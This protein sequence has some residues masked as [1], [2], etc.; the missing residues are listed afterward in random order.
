GVRYSHIID[1]ET[2]RPI[3]HRTASVTVLAESAMMAD[4]WATAFLALGREQGME[5]AEKYE[6]A[7]FFIDRDPLGGEGRFETAA[8]PQFAALQASSA[9]N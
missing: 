2:G 1:G 8:S 4:A 7:A 3:T 5:I 9:A 6:I